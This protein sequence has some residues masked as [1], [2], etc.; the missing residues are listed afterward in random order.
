MSGVLTDKDDKKSAMRVMMVATVA[1][2][3]VVAILGI[4]L[5]RD[6][7]AIA[8]LVGALL[9]PAFIGKAVQGRGGQ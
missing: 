8:A 3:C 5:N 7:V 4:A 1:T 6:P 2:G 9:G